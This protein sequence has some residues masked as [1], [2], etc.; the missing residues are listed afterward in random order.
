[1]NIEMQHSVCLILFNSQLF[2]LVWWY[3]PGR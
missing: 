3:T 2:L 1:M